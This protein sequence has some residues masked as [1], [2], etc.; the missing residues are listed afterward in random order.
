MALTLVGGSG[1][2]RRLYESEVA[3]LATVIEGDIDP[4]LIKVSIGCLY[5]DS[6]GDLVIPTAG[7]VT[8]M[9]K[10]ENTRQ[11]EEIPNNVIDSTV[12][13]TLPVGANIISVQA[14]PS[15]LAGGSIA[16][17]QLCV[18]ANKGN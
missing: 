15:A 14:T 4:S 9:V 5:L 3:S 2:D 6:G 11:W 12:P 10:T 1:G 18:T 17:Y 16:T 13:T 7:T 8:I